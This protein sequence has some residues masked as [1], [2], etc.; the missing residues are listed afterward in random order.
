[1]CR[2]HSSTVFTGSVAAPEKALLTPLMSVPVLSASSMIFWYSVG[3]PGTQVGVCF[4]MIFMIW[5]IFGAGSRMTSPPMSWPSVALKVR[6]Y[7]WNIGKAASIRSSLSPRPFTQALP[8][9]RLAYSEPWVS[10]APFG[11]PVVPEV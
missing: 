1:M 2:S 5:S 4:F 6:P 8:M 9:S 7:A 3:T 10:S 11:S